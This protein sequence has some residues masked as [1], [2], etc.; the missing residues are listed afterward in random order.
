ME[1]IKR[2]LVRDKDSFQVH[3][4]SILDRVSQQPPLSSRLTQNGAAHTT[5]ITTNA[6][7]EVCWTPPPP[8][9][10]CP[11]SHVMYGYLCHVLLG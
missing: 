8:P 9:S 7:L 11:R 4:Q 3:L 6:E 5:I 10:Y 1:Y 2:Q